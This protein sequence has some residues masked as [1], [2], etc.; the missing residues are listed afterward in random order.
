MTLLELWVQLNCILFKQNPCRIQFQFNFIITSTFDCDIRNQR[1]SILFGLFWLWH[2]FQKRTF[3]HYL[4]CHYS[5]FGHILR[6]HLIVINPGSFHW[7]NM[8]YIYVMYFMHHFHSFDN[9]RIEILRLSKDVKFC[10]DNKT[11][12]R[13]WQY[14]QTYQKIL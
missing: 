6:R 12:F 1:K 3:F 13:L 2:L 10:W 11:H 14:I 8:Y 7:I 9:K 4:V 5:Y